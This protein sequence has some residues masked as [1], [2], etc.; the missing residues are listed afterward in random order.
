MAT[1]KGL[2]VEI[3]AKTTS[4]SKALND[5]S[6]GARSAQTEL[7]QVQKA[8][9]MK[10]DSLKLLTRQSELLE[11]KIAK[12]TQRLETLKQVMANTAREDMA[13]GQWEKLQSDINRCETSLKSFTKQLDAVQ[14]KISKINPT[15]G[16]V[17][18]K[19]TDFGTK[20]E[21]AGDKVSKVGDTLTRTLTPAIVAAGAASVAAAVQMD[22]SLTNV[23]KT[24]DGTEQQYQ[25][26]KDSAIEFSKTNA[27]SASQILDIQ[28]LGAQLGFSIDELD[29]FGEVVSGLDIATNMDAETAATE[30]AQFANITKMSHDDIER[31]AS[32]IVGLGNN[33]ATTESDISAMA[34][35]IAAAGTQVG[36]SQADILGLATA[37]S[38]LGV[39]AEA[40]GTAVSTVIAN[41]DKAV[42]T[43]GDSLN[44]WANAAQMSAQEF[45]QTWKT[46]PV[47]ALASVLS[48]LEG[49]T[50]AG[51]NMSLMLEDLGVDAL[52]QT[53]VLK[54][55]AGNSDLVS[56]AVSKSNEEWQKNTALSREVENRNE[57][58]AAKFEMLKNRVI[59]IADD[60]GGPLADALLDAID[61]MQ[62]LID[63][64][65]NGAQAF[66]D[67][68]KRSQQ[69]VITCV[70]LI[71]ALGPILKLAGQ[72]P[73]AAKA[74][75]AAMTAL[76]KAIGSV[77]SI[78]D[79]FS[80]GL[81]VLTGGLAAVAAAVA[82][83]GIADIAMDFAEAQA[84]EELLNEASRDFSDIM[85]AV[86]SNVEEA[87]G[88]LD[89]YSKSIDDV[90]EASTQA[91]KDTIAL[92]DAIED[93]LTEVHTNGALLDKY[94]DTIDRL[95]NKSN[96]SASEQSE[97]K[98]AVD[99]L[100]SILG[101]QYQIVDATNGKIADQNGV[102][103]EN[104]DAINANADAWY[105]RA[106]A[107]AVSSAL[108][109]AYK[110]Q[111]EQEQKLTE[112]IQKRDEL[113]K[114]IDSGEA[115]Y[116]DIKDY[117]DA[118]QA[119]ED[120]N[121]ALKGTN[122]I[123]DGLETKAAKLNSTLSD[124][125]LA[126]VEKLPDAA[127]KAG[128]DVAAKLQEGVAAGTINAQ[129]AASFLTDTVAG[130]LEGL[131]E[132]QY[133]NGM[134]VAL[135]L[136][137]GVT[138]GSITPQ[139]A[140]AFMTNAIGGTV[141]N[142]PVE[143]QGAGMQAAL[144]L[145]TALST[146][147]V[148]VE[149]AAT[150]LNAAAKGKLN[151]L[152]AE[153]QTIGGQAVTNLN[154]AIAGGAGGTLAAATQVETSATT[155]LHP[156]PG[157]YSSIGSQSGQSL[158]NTL[159]GYAGSVGT[160]ATSLSTAAQDGVAPT[161]QALQQ[162]GTEA[163]TGF[164]EGVASGVGPTQTASGELATA[165][166]NAKNNNSSASSWGSELGNNFAAGIASAWSAVANA[167]SSI[168]QAAYDFLHHTTP[169]KGPL[170]DD[171]VWGK[172]LA[173]NFSD[174]MKKGVPDVEKKAELLAQTVADYIAHSHPKKG[175]LSQGEWIFG[176]HA[177]VNFAEGLASGEDAVRDAA[178]GLAGAAADELSESEKEMQAYI[179]NMIAG[180]ED[181]SDEFRESSTT[182]GDALWG[183]MYEGIMDSP[184]RKPATGAV[185]DSMK[186]LES[187]GY[188]LDSYKQAVEDFANEKAEWDEKLAGTLSES[189]Q[190]SYDSWLKDYEAFTDMQSKLT[191]GII[192]L[193]TFQGL[194]K[195]KDQAISGIDDAQAWSD[196][197]TKLFT[198]TGVVY[199][200]DFIDAI[201]DGNGEYLQAVQQMGD[202]TSEQ[203]QGMVDA[204]TDLRVAQE[205]QE[206]MQR[207]LYVSSL[208][209][210]DTRTLKERLIDYSNTMLDVQ[211]ALYSDSGLSG[212]FEH[213]G[214][215]VEGFAADLMSVD[216]TM[217]DFVSN[218][219]DYTASVSSGFDR[220]TKNGASSLADWEETLKL[221]MA[222]S[223]AYA[224]NIE[225]V[226]SKI[227]ENIDVSAFREAVM[228][229]GLEQWGQV[230]EDMAS[231]SGE[232]IASYIE[233][234]NQS[235]Q[236]AQTDMINQFKAMAPGEEMLSS[237][238][239]GITANTDQISGAMEGVAGVANGALANQGQNFYA[240]GQA[241]AGQVAAGIASQI[242]AIASAAASVVS[243]AIGAAKSAASSGIASVSGYSAVSGRTVAA[244]SQAPIM[245]MA[246]RSMAATQ[247][248]SIS[249]PVNNVSM[250]FTVNTQPG[251]TVDVRSL[252][253]EI[254]NLQEREM[255]SRGLR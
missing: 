192:D 187:Q 117:N 254:N 87:S 128:V 185:Y 25:A 102:I 143:M 37:L 23:R 196:A 1:Y 159:G 140:A 236:Q 227:P 150:I 103:Q 132:G 206:L 28:A 18:D 97:L 173:K 152:P 177:A 146:G 116:F 73:A 59:A 191:A 41:I 226:F 84:H 82:V 242:D 122:D 111:I 201:M 234:Y 149:Q 43:G 40:G 29:E 181:R 26:L 175:P 101:T 136:A 222:E 241:L 3:G 109:D 135:Q 44:A 176:Y 33:F 230:M 147:Q 119:V 228:S 255:R 54:R 78:A 178:E 124:E 179:D 118:V 238:I 27:V 95:A 120:A 64:I 58:L 74:G 30:L 42:S 251:Q 144:S 129:T 209:Y 69:L 199:N 68:D 100:N 104:T 89:G 106:E 6:K 38:S 90:S 167:A 207:A 72:I 76:A 125:M 243:S 80:K 188:D 237:V 200:Q 170:R 158:A 94:T 198:K 52:R 91:L 141:S 2:T 180:W 205:Q 168:A 11:E 193:E 229:G 57:S 10:P 24:V 88:S 47:E 184:W 183:G 217:E 233:L 133:Q 77:T 93:S 137:N 55:M 46:S 39:E 13:D 162:A 98:T 151:T 145:A 126:A 139:Q 86:S 213:A 107:E 186:I 164:S 131:P 154:A 231:L 194:Y 208:K 249:A 142:L 153:L 202:M 63:A 92:G 65:A 110:Q 211:E 79:L 32:S 220:F 22:T 214:A 108:G 114:K 62:P 174:G 252:A 16:K 155:P 221:N 67:M 165:T 216:M 169:E 51:G 246:G 21:K 203:V 171:D 96:L 50:E 81:T 210:G 235:I 45:A 7:K 253:K 204:Y 48:G 123:I 9:K 8:L 36:M 20:Y 85:S 66:A 35:R 215:T 225:T 224:D 61:C 148:S 31:F 105:R 115:N 218:L 130:A 60:I 17:G 161:P 53:D 250:S 219:G 190:K 157:E 239:S 99:G 197:L 223:Q 172:H 212:A 71:A 138:A 15:L 232:Q 70:A 166:E 240:T 4:L 163:G 248:A 12:T 83:V 49:A 134:N 14:A 112:A 160:S 247:A 189:D 75:G 34:M 245:A 244:A 19:L 5:I 182:I 127:Q 156:M 121:A 195:L 56:E 113:Q